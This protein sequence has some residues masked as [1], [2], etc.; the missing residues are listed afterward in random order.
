MTTH[1]FRDDLDSAAAESRKSYWLDFY[2]QAFPDFYK[3]VDVAA[4]GRAQRRGIDRCVLLRDGTQ[5]R[6]QEKFRRNY[7]SSVLIEEWSDVERKTPGWSRAPADAY[8][9]LA[10]VTPSERYG[11]LFPWPIFRQTLLQFGRDWSRIA[12]HKT[13]SSEHNGRRWQTDCF[14]ID[15]RVLLKHVEGSR[16]V[17]W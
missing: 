16:E 5:Y 6:M 4:D 13:I 1:S 15:T 3:I 14:P 8:D 10:Y 12:E 9:F 11:L 7:Y 17:R 2:R